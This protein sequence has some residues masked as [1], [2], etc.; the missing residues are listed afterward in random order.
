MAWPILTLTFK[1]LTA[2]F[3][4]GAAVGLWRYFHRVFSGSHAHEDGSAKKGWDHVEHAARHESLARKNVIFLLIMLGNFFF[5]LQE[6]VLWAWSWIARRRYDEFLTGMPAALEDPEAVSD[7]L[8]DR[9]WRDILTELTRW[10][11]TASLVKWPRLQPD[12]LR[13]D[14]SRNPNWLEVRVGRHVYAVRIDK[15]RRVTFR[16]LT[17]D[18]AP[19]RHVS[20]ATLIDGQWHNAHWQPETKA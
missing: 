1:L 12:G 16:G 9:P 10:L 5:G 8:A 20:I 17:I 13:L 19:D 18:V 11:M 14:T 2:K 15:P 4:K 7:R 6:L 3:L